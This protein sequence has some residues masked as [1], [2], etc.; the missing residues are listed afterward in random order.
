MQMK[1]MDKAQAIDIAGQMAFSAEARVNR[2]LLDSSHLLV[3]MNCYE[4]GQVTPMHKHPGQ[5]EVLYIVEGAG[6]VSFEDSE[7][8]PVE[9][10]QLVC[11][12]GDQFHRIEAGP[13]GRMVMIYFLNPEYSRVRSD[14]HDTN[15]AVK[16]LPGEGRQG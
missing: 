6:T 8:L 10:G 14:T 15:A 3:R 12:P 16:R 4:P 13:D 9:A 1:T 2:E 7:D 5:D 11:L